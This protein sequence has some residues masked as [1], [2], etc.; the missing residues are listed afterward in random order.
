MT[1]LDV[2]VGGLPSFLIILNT[3]L[4]FGLIIFTILR[5]RDSYREKIPNEV[6]E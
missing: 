4:V 1:N 3:V 5:I 6:K 2:L